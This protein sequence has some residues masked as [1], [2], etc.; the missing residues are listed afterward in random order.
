MSRILFHRFHNFAALKCRRLQHRARQV[1][2]VRVARQARDH[3]AR[4]LLPV[5]RVQSRKRRHKIHAAVVLHA[6]RQRLDVRTFLNHPKIVPKPLHQRARDGDASFQRIPRRFAPKLVRDGRQ[7]AEVRRHASLAGVHQQES[8]R[9]RTYF[10]LPRAGSTFAPPAP[11]ADL[12]GFPR[13]ARPRTAA[14]AAA[15]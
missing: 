9:C 8:S 14:K 12:P 7:Q 6:S 2:L 13:Q 11:P 3:S 5:R 15:P 10:S 4:A 1:P